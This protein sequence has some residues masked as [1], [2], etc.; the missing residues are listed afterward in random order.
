MEK[1]QLLKSFGG[2]LVG[3][4]F[5]KE[6]VVQAVSKLPEDLISYI[7]QNV[8]FLSSAPDAWAYTFHGQ[9]IPDKYLVLLTD[10]LFHEPEWQIQYTIL[11]EIGHVVLKH[12]NSIEVKQTKQEIADQEERAD[13]FA[14]KYL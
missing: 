6:Q 11:H 5:M 8:W 3:N 14:K 4:S 2:R 9:D 12:R 1:T 10:E 7:T 13:Q